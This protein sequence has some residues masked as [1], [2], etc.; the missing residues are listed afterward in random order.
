ML[1]IAL[2]LSDNLKEKLMYINPNLFFLIKDGQFIVWDYLHHTQFTLEP[3]YMERLR[4]WAEGKVESLSSIDDELEEAQLIAK[5]PFIQQ[6]W[7]W[8]D[9]S[10]IFHIGTR[11]IAEHLIGLSREEW[12]ES[13]LAYCNTIATHPPAF[14]IKKEAEIKVPLPTPDLSLLDQEKYYSVVK[15]RK[16]N[17]YFKGEKIS[18]DIL[19]ALLF[20]SLGPLHEKWSDLEENGLQILGRRKSFPSAGGLH[21]EEAYLIALRVEGLTPGIYHYDSVDHHLTLIEEKF[22]EEEL[23]PLLY[24]QY[25]AEGLAAGI[26]L[27][28]RFEKGWWK[29]PHS[30][31]YRMTLIDIG[32]ASQSLVLTATALGLDTWMTGAFSDS[33][34]EKFLSLNCSTEQPIFFIGFG[35]GHSSTLEPHMLSQLSV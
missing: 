13:Y 15:R 25:F 10:K 22:A 30:R 17:R 33:Q 6:E 16:T 1:R 14:H 11:D 21:P 35:Q 29:Y 24:G 9:L 8:D 7:G 28:S 19:S 34:V 31:G 2:G 4:L 18:L 20:V 27:T 5:E 12:I 26:F 3:D 23:I 32:H